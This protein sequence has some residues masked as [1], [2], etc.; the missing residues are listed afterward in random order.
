MLNSHNYKRIKERT[1]P[2]WQEARGSL[3]RVIE[4]A[5]E[6]LKT[7]RRLVLGAGAVFAILVV[8][9]IVRGPWGAG[10]QPSGG[11]RPLAVVDV[12]RAVRKPVPVRVE[13]L[14]TVTTIASVAIKSRVDTEIVQV[15]FT[16]GARVKAG[17]ILFTLDSRTLE[18]QI[19]QAEGMVARDQ[20][21]LDGAERDVRRYTDLV[22][23]GATPTI[24]LDNGMTQA[25]TFRAAMKADQAALENLK[26]QLSYC[27]IHAPISGRVSTA[28][29]KVGNFVR[30]A[31]LPPLATINQIAPIYVTFAVPQGTLPDVR[32]AISAETATIEA[33]IPGESKRSQGQVTVIE[34]TVDPSTGTVLIRATMPN[35]DE[36]LWPGTLVTVQLT[37]RIEDVVVVP[38]VVVQ[39]SQTGTY[40][41]VIKNGVAEVRPVKVSRSVDNMSVIAE[42][43]E[44]DEV[45]VTNGQLSLSNGTKVSPREV[46]VGS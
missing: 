45:V 26:V 8:V 40:V 5:R 24:N 31:D 34:N 46:K 4:R 13:A 14:G 25:D 18:A 37:L 12:I 30:Q 2:L 11:A 29:V 33:L 6:L 28:S 10:A 43:L 35:A 16:D 15:H 39:A 7:R 44:N 32:R 38:S 36:I 41:F 27:V 1:A 19:R 42:G 9:L 23:K 21:Q 3:I 17:D 20:A 22:A